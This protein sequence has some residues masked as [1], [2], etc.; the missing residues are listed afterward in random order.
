MTI[1]A[2]VVVTVVFELVSSTPGL[3]E[4]THGSGSLY[5]TV[6]HVAIAVPALLLTAFGLAVALVGFR[7]YVREAGSGPKAR[8]TAAILTRAVAETVTLRWLDGGGGDCYYPDPE[9]PSAERRI[10]HHLLVVGLLLAFAA[11]I[12]AAFA[13]YVL[14]RDPPYGLFSVPV[15]LGTVGGVAVV[16]ASVGLLIGNRVRPRA[17]ASAASERGDTALLTSLLLVAITGIVLLIVQKAS[18]QLRIVLL[19][20]LGAVAGL[21]LFAPYGKLMHAVYRFAA[22][23]VDVR[24]RAANP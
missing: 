16:F 10:A 4:I 1:A 7:L 3:F 19:V 21:Y 2:I 12:S 15:I 13:E 11:T 24:E 18:G 6:S 8:L 20:H 14:G 9:A 5:R 23:V 22:I 17:L